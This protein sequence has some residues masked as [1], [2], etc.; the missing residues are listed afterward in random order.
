MQQLSRRQFL[1]R[2]SACLSVMALSSRLAQ[3][4]PLGLPPGLQL[5]SVSS[6]IQK[7]AA[8][9]LKQVAAIGFK[10]VE[11]AGFG[12]LKTATEFRKAL[13]DAG[14]RCPSAHLAF[15]LKNLGKTFDDANALGCTYATASVPRRMLATAPGAPAAPP[16]TTTGRGNGSLYAMTPDEVKKLAETLN[17]VGKAA[18]AAG[19]K[20]ASHNHNF[21]FEPMGRSTAYDYLLAH[22][23]PALV[24]FEIDCGWTTVAGYKPV[25]YLKHYPGRFK[26]IHMS[27]YLPLT[28]AWDK[29]TVP[30]GAELGV[31]F[32]PYKQIIADLRHDGIEHVFVEQAGPYPRMSQMDAV[33]VDYSFLSSFKD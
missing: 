31:G 14:L 6:D 1:S 25:D 13:D 29:T 4:F 7:D 32:V 30:P 5:Y 21:E 9:A 26:M 10:E 22:T 17:E 18:K 33:K 24:N 19:L 28:S 27:D 11:P 2:G 3:A 20:Y 12:T 15:D 16:A 8:A 23:D